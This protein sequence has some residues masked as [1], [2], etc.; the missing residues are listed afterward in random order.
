M[1]WRDKSLA[2]VLAGLESTHRQLLEMM[3]QIDHVEIDRRRDRNGRIITIR[4]YVIDVM[5]EHERQHATEIEAWRRQLDRSIDPEAIKA[6]LGQNQRDFWAALGELSEAEVQ[7][8]SALGD[9]SIQDVVGH[10]ADWEQLILNAARHIHDPSWPPAPLGSD[11]I[12]EWNELMVARRASH[13]WPEEK[14]YLSE[15]QAAL[16]EFI[17]KLKPGDW[18]LRGPYPWPNDQGSLAELIWHAAEHYAE[19]L[20]G[21]AR[22]RSQN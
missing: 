20:P 5:A 19:H 16:D 21:V 10:I 14:R 15:T 17:D 8:K 13:T 9:W 4:S 11:N 3:A 12:D 18:K 6:T 22:W 2:D 1:A 7:D